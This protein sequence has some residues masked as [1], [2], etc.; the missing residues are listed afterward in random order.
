[1][2]VITT[3]DA[4]SRLPVRADGDDHLERLVSVA[5]DVDW[6]PQPGTEQTIEPI[7]SR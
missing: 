7:T 1:M 6:R 5:V 4:V 3:L 2:G